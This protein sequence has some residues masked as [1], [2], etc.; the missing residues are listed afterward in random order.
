M[1]S[2]ATGVSTSSVALRE[3]S[4][5][6]TFALDSGANNFTVLAPD[7]DAIRDLPRKPWEDPQDYSALGPKA[8]EGEDGSQRANRNLKNFVEAH[9]VLQSPWRPGQKAKTAKGDDIWL[10]E[11]DGKWMIRP[12]NVEVSR[13]GEQVKNGEVWVLEKCLNYSK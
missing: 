2:A 12:S 8:Y 11:K 10:E 13:I 9:I 7:N 3:T 6:T 1:S 4:I 5:P